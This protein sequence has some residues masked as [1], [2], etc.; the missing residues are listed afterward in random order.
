MNGVCLSEPQGPADLQRAF[1]MFYGVSADKIDYYG[2][3]EAFCDVSSGS[4]MYLV[5]T[6][7]KGDF[8]QWV[9]LY[10]FP[11]CSDIE[12]AGFLA[13]ALNT[14][15]LISDDTVNDYRWIVVSK[16]SQRAVFVNADFLDQFDG[17]KI[18]RDTI[19]N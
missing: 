10:G 15:I 16:E 12:I 7:L 19:S 6:S 13:K 2:S 8:P 3:F 9:D 4:G 14:E 1:A 5:E 11:E 17:F 18:D